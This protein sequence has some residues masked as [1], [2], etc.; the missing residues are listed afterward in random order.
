MSGLPGPIVTALP[1]PTLT[2]AA[3]RYVSQQAGG[4]DV[5]IERD[6]LGGQPDPIAAPLTVAFSAALSPTTPGGQPI[7]AP[8]SAAAPF[9]PV[10]ESITFPAGV[11][12]ESV[13]IPVDAGAA[14]PGSVPIG[15][16]VTAPGYSAAASLQ[17]VSGPAVPP[18]PPA[19]TNAHLVLHGGRA[20]GI[21]ITFSAPM[22]PA[23]VANVHAYSVHSWRNQTYYDY[24]G[25]T[26][27]KSL[28]GVPIPLQAAPYDPSTHTVTLIPRSPL[29]TSDLITIQNAPHRGA[30]TTL[31]DLQG[32]ALTMTYPVGA[33]SIRAVY[34]RGLLSVPPVGPTPPPGSFAFTMRGKESLTWAAPAPNVPGG[35]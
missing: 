6:D 34:R 4:F 21:A 33:P 10:S 7:A 32:T 9:T 8:A 5:T 25:L 17:L 18:T 23:A 31:S 12:T 20:S 27:W 22:S 2:I 30:S 35:G 3:P 28:T 11:T 29:K 13:H 24:F 26:H 1:E 15:L 14:N 19:I 16:F